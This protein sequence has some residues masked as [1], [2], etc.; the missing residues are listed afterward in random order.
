MK[1]K[2]PNN[3]LLMQRVHMKKREVL[4]ALLGLATLLEKYPDKLNLEHVKAIRDTNALLEYLINLET[5]SYKVPS[6]TSFDGKLRCTECGAGLPLFNVSSEPRCIEHIPKTITF[7][8]GMPN[9]ELVASGRKAP[10]WMEK[11]IWNK[12]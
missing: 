5:I 7:P 12:K 3:S 6:S 11:S 10:D 1:S 8:I 9:N 2:A 4:T